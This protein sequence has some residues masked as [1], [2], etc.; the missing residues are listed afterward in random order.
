M[1]NK[2]ISYIGNISFFIGLA[3]AIYVFIYLFLLNKNLPEGVCPIDQKRPFLY[4]S[5][6][7]IVVSFILSFFEKKNNK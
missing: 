5:I 4:V 2:I 3:L 1:K 6:G 7:F